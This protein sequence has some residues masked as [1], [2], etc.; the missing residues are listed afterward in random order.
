MRVV[1][2][3]TWG[4]VVAVA[5]VLS[6]SAALTAPAQAAD[7]DVRTFGSDAFGQLGNGAAGPTSTPTTVLKGAS[8]VAGGREHVLALRAGAVLAWG[9]DSFGQL[10]N[11]SPLTSAT[12]PV[13]VL[14]GARDVATGHLHSLAL[15]SDGGVRLWG[16]NDK[17]QIGPS[18]GSGARVASPV[19][20]TLPGAASMVAA[21]R[22]HSLAVVGGRV[23]AWGDNTY[24]QLGRG[25]ADGDRHSDPQVVSG[26]PAVRFVAGGRDSSYAITT[27]GDLYAWGRNTDGQI[28][29]G[30]TATA[31]RPVKVLSGVRQVESGAEHTVAVR[32]DDTVWTWGSGAL[33]QLGYAASTSTRPRRVTSLPPVAKAYVGRDH[34]IA[35]ARNGSTLTWGRNDAGQLGVPAS[36]SRTTPAVVPGLAGARDAGGGEKYTVVLD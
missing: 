17:G 33:G 2:S 10:G 3:R 25:T 11:G 27:S 26:L 31:L 24:G 18:G 1:R 15:L 13:Q 32:G 28:G 12:S 20:V 6:T 7:G 14:T 19:A 5:A 36:G 23:L 9:A 35:L 22:A 4:S 16:S 29:S 21:G 34:S 8:R 30:S